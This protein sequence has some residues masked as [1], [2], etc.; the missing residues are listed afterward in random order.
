MELKHVGE[1]LSLR[2]VKYLKFIIICHAVL[3]FSSCGED[4][5]QEP[6]C[7][8]GAACDDGLNTTTGDKLS[9]DCV[10]AGTPT[11]CF[12]IGDA[13]GDGICSD[14]DCDDLDPEVHTLDQDGDGVCGDVDCDDNDSTN[15]LTDLDGDGYCSDVDCNDQNEASFPGAPCSDGNPG[16]QNDVLNADCLCIGEPITGTLTDPRDSVEYRTVQIGTKIWMAE[17]LHYETNLY[18]CYDDD[19]ANCEIYGK[20]YRWQTALDVCPEGWH[21][22][23]VNEWQQ[24]VNW[25]GGNDAGGGAMKDTLG[26]NEPNTG[27]TNA[28]GF[29]ALPG[30]C[31][32]FAGEFSNLNDRG[33]W[34][35]SEESTSD[36]IW[37]RALN[38]NNSEVSLLGNHRGDGMSVR[39]VK[40]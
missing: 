13:D 20:L 35:S 9:A 7:V 15:I 28:S 8:V 5:I 10:C 30:G 36:N 18:W 3:L 31:R 19:P 39:C 25:V 12:T 14:L 2:S 1:S 6:D 37:T 23:S 27:A 16:T 26:W 21:L 17:N 29:A 4:T 22:P 11:T 33:F 32:T 38:Y 34:W 40:D 24:A